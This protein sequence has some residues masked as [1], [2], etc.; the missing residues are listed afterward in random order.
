MRVLSRLRAPLALP[1]VLAFLVCAPPCAAA[2]GGS[3]ATTGGIAGKVTEVSTQK[4]I[5]GIEVCAFAAGA[6]ISNEETEGEADCIKTGAAGEYSI[7]ALPAGSYTVGFGDPFPSTLNYV[8]QFYN[9]KSSP[10]EATPVSVSV[11]A[12][13]ENIDGVLEEGAEISGTTTSAATGAPIEGALVCAAKAGASPELVGCAFSGAGGSYTVSG[14]PAGSY[15]VLS[16]GA[17]YAFEYYDNVGA[18]AEATAVTVGAREAKQGVDLALPVLTVQ[19]VATTGPQ[20][21]VGGAVGLPGS[22]GGG[23]AGGLK[24]AAKAGVSLLDARLAVSRRNIALVKLT[25]SAPAACRGKL[26]LT[27][28]R[29]RKHD[30]KSLPETVTIGAVDFSLKAGKSGT[31]AIKLGPTGRDLLDAAKGKL[32]A[33]L[34]IVQLA[35]AS[36]HTAV[37]RVLL[38]AQKRAAVKP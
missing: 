24:G 13:S 18:I 31:I 17:G 9:G 36:S 8:T 22:G 20:A 5:A 32:A 2:E 14:L 1:A 15:D 27:E 7:S 33:H 26:A 29:T 11:G 30:G 19:P 4:A 6:P 34:A 16:G 28:K 35:P 37:K 10:A 21:P 25:C 3:T 38:I 23:L 12:V